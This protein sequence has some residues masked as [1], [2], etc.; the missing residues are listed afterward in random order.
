MAGRRKP[1][2]IGEPSS[3]EA[4]LLQSLQGLQQGNRQEAMPLR[5]QAFDLAETVRGSIDGVPFEWIAD[6]DAR[7][8]PCLEIILKTGYAWVPFSRLRAIAFDAP[9]DLRDKVWSPVRITWSHGGE[10]IG[11][12]PTRYPGSELAADSDLV[13]ARRTEWTDL[14]DDCFVGSGQ[15][16]LVTDAGEY[17]LLDIRSLSFELA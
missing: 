17:P 9:T 13:L 2:V 6:A 7:F 12:V 1:T 3:W 16:M 4:M 14:G 10:A 8:G 15:R 5:E 11:F